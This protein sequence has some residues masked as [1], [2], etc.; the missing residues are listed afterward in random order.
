MT[1]TQYKLGLLVAAA[2]ALAA[3]VMTGGVAASTDAKTPGLNATQND[4]VLVDVEFNS[5]ETVTATVNLTEGGTTVNSTTL[6][7][8][9]VEFAD[10][11]GI[12]T[13]EFELSQN[14]TALN[15]SVDASPASGF[16]QMWVSVED[17]SGFLGGGGVVAGASQEQLLGFGAVVVVLV[18]AYNRDVF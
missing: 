7:F 14:Y 13:A 9:P 1:R 18:A 5:T 10:G 11:Q 17:D 4:S 12:K 16:A 2:V 15:A 3:V 6:S 8:D